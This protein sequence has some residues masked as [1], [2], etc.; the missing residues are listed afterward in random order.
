MTR[1][2]LLTQLTLGCKYTNIATL[3]LSTTTYQRRTTTRLIALGRTIEFF[4][5]YFKRRCARLTQMPLVAFVRSPRF[6]A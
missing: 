4:I 2:A 1:H 5:A 6:Y 3:S